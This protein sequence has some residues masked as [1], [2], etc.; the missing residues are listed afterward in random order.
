MLQRIYIDN[1]KCLVN[2]EVE[3][4]ELT[5][6]LGRNGSGKSSVVDVLDRLRRLIAGE[7]KVEKLFPSSSLTR[8]QSQRTQ[9]FELS[10]KGNGG[11]YEYMLELEHEPDGAVKI[12]LEQL[13]Y[14]GMP[15]VLFDDGVVSM[16]HEDN[17][18]EG[19]AEVVLDW[20]RSCFSY[21]LPRPNQEKV[22]WFIQRMTFFFV[23]HLDP[24]RMTAV[25][26]EE[27]ARPDSALTDFASWYRSLT[28]EHPGTIRE[29]FD[30]LQDIID[31]FDGLLLTR[32]QRGRKLLQ[33]H[34]RADA[35]QAKPQS[36][37]FDELSDGERV[38]IALYTLL[39]FQIHEGATVCL[40]EPGNFVALEELQPWLF[41]LE[42]HLE[43]WGG[44]V[45]LIS[46]H[47][48]LLDQLA[49]SHGKVFK[50]TEAGPTRIVG[51]EYDRDEPLTP[52]E[53]VAR[54][55]Q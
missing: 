2:T 23:L 4:G 17:H 31:G 24:T 41:A 47:P 12:A 25:S 49:T 55:W 30:D 16:P 15:L 52:S 3:F 9:S 54:G 32:D 50:R 39:R 53:V 20:S 43:D 26:E 34:R 33:I 27:V 28:Q 42:E 40:D 46:H 6:L 13:R 1:Y 21:I 10:I 48:Q 37:N 44:Q 11:L 18:R 45:L 35:A 8:W 7:A 14:D 38:L 5:L 51:F 19:V 22:R 29:L 36:Y